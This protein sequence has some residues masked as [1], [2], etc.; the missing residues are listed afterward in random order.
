[1]PA[2]V[3]SLCLMK[4]ETPAGERYRIHR[5]WLPWRRRARAD[6]LDWLPDLP[7]PDL[8]VGD[9]PIG[10]VIVAILLIPLLAILALVLGEVLLLLLL[11]PFFVL[12][13][14]VFGTPWVIEVSQG[15]KILH[16]EAVQGWG[17]STR[18]IER[19]ASQ[20]RGGQ[21]P[22]GDLP[23]DEQRQAPVQYWSA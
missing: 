5:R 10:L 6:A 18:R 14:S 1:V 7:G 12:A 13:R 4:V 20:V 15:H 2:V 3:A 22:P 9:D 17:A 11:L 8:D 21:L 16:L 19:L 23:Q